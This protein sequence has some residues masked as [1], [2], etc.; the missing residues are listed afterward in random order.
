M[1]FDMNPN[2]EHPDIHGECKN[3]I[4]KLEEEVKRLKEALAVYA[5][6]K[7]WFHDADTH[8]TRFYLV[9]NPHGWEIAEKALKGEK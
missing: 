2:D 8:K 5:N 4:E 3:E 1:S 9:G 6:K 7:N